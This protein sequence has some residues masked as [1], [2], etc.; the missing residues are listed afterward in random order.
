MGK[1][2]KP[3][4]TWVPLGFMNFHDLFNHILY[5]I[6]ITKKSV[7]PCPVACRNLEPELKR[8]CASKGGAAWVQLTVDP[9]E[10]LRSVKLCLGCLIG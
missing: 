4:Q 8:R 2:F 7:D 3:I 5:F 9:V 1:V 6:K 10:R